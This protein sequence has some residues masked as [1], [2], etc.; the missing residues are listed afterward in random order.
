MK[1]NNS[2]CQGDV[3]FL[4]RGRTWGFHVRYRPF[5]Q[6]GSVITKLGVDFYAKETFFRITPGHADCGMKFDKTFTA[7]HSARV[8]HLSSSPAPSCCGMSDSLWASSARLSLFATACG[9]GIFST[10][11]FLL[12]ASPEAGLA[13]VSPAAVASRPSAP[14][15]SDFDFEAEAEAVSFLKAH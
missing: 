5:C 4:K 11:R 8:T 6:I 1:N 12:R 3:G 13:V 9:A 2:C 14:P 10:F 15:S 7:W